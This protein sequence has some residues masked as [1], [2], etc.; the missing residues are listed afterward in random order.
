VRSLGQRQKELRRQE[1]QSRLRAD[2]D[3]AVAERDALADELAE[4]YPPLV[5]KLADLM[6]ALRPTTW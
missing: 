2:F 1:H 5:E 6:T 3:A 4:V